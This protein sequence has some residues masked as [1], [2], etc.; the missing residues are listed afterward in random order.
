MKSM[1]RRP[2]FA[3]ITGLVVVLTLSTGCYKEM[4]PDATVTSAGEVVAE[5]S[6]EDIMATAAARTTRVAEEEAAMESVEEPSATVEGEEAPPEPVEAA[7]EVPTDI[8]TEPVV[9]ITAAPTFTPAPTE[10]PAAST[11]DTTAP[12]TTTSTGTGQTTHV[13][14]RGENL[15]RIALRYGTTVQ[16]VSSANGIANPGMIYVGQRLTIPSSGSAPAPAPSTGSATTH[17]VR[18]GENLFRIALR[19]NLNYHYLAQ[20]NGI[21]NPANIYVGQVLR[22]PPH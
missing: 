18:A 20:Y 21:S 8:P 2:M 17:V 9:I 6:Q 22:I 1:A 11:T 4:A 10:P 19:Y 12:A 16:A 3:L 13:V 7:T 14:Q 5:L 15:F